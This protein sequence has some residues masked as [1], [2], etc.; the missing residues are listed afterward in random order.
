MLSLQE[1]CN[2]KKTG[3]QLSINDFIEVTSRY[4]GKE[5][6]Q[7]EMGKYITKGEPIRFS[8]GMLSD[9]FCLSFKGMVPVI[10]ITDE[11]KFNATFR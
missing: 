4:V 2:N 8:K 5:K 1:F 3:Y 9:E 6:I 7:A 11:K 10:G